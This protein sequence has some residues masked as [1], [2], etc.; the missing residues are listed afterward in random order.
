MAPRKQDKKQKSRFASV[1]EAVEAYT[2]I[3]MRRWARCPNGLVRELGLPNAWD[4]LNEAFLNPIGLAEAA[5]AHGLEVNPK[6]GAL[7]WDGQDVEGTD[8]ATWNKAPVPGA[9]PMSVR[10]ALL[11]MRADAIGVRMPDSNSLDDYEI[12]IVKAEKASV[13]VAMPTRDRLSIV[14]RLAE[15]NAATESPQPGDVM[16]QTGSG[17][18]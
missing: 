1:D 16:N 3:R 17:Q 5:N 14:E 9:Q 18:T 7:V 11:R 10:W 6:T 8:D 2:N 4:E 13:G 12:L 15:S